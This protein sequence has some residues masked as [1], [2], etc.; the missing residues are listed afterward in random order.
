[1]GVHWSAPGFVTWYGIEQETRTYDDKGRVAEI[2]YGSGEVRLSVK[3]WWKLLSK[4]NEKWF[5]PL[6]K[7]QN[8]TVEDL[9]KARMPIL[10]RTKK[11]VALGGGD[12]KRIQAAEKALRDFDDKQQA[13]FL[14]AFGASHVA[15]IQQLAFLPIT[16]TAEFK[17]SEAAAPD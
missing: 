10:E 9:Q 1:N 16:K 14:E 17:A 6:T 15:R 4:A 2:A 13:R 7:E 8:A 12:E 5:P 3:D 11:A